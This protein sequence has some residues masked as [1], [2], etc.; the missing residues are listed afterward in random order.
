MSLVLLKEAM[1]EVARSL[2]ASFSHVA[3][4]TEEKLAATMS[5]VRAA[6]QLSVG[7]MVKAATTYPYLA[8]L[9]PI[10]DPN[11]RVHNNFPLVRQH[12]VELARTK[13]N[14]DMQHLFDTDLDHTSPSL[15]QRNQQLAG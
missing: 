11:A 1:W 6:E 9:I 7:K 3:D 13:L 4:T 10:G 2:Q 15:T 5:F 12:A 8:S 14:E